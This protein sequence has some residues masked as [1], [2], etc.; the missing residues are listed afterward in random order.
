MT[1]SAKVILHSLC[2]DTSSEI[3]TMELKYPRIIH[4]EFMTHRM[5]SRNAASSRAIPIKRMME[6]VQE[7]VAM[8]AQWGTAKPGMQAGDEDSRLKHFAFNIWNRA[9]QY[10]IYMADSMSKLGLHKQIANRLLEPFSHMTVLMT[11]TDLSNFFR[12]RAHPEADPTFQTLAYRMLRVYLESRSRKL[13]IGEWHLPFF[14]AE[15]DSELGLEDR[16]KVCTARCARVSYL[17]HDGTREHSAD[18]EMHDR[19]AANG[20]WSPFEHCAKAAY[21][22]FNIGNFRGWKSYRTGLDTLSRMKATREELET[23]LSTEPEWVKSV[24]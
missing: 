6:M 4:S 1:I 20:H 18:L 7:N 5:F 13:S 24:P 16:L 10:A 14:S 19:L 9:A 23:I 2:V 8:P 11:A 3:I 22:D 17:T 15:F 12:L 21:G